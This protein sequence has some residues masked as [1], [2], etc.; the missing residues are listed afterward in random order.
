[1]KEAIQHFACNFKQDT[2]RFVWDL[3]TIGFAS[4]LGSF[5]NWLLL[6]GAAMLI[7]GRL[8]LLFVNGVKRFRDFNKPEWKNI[9][10][11]V[12]KKEAIEDKKKSGWRKLFDF[13]KLG[14]KP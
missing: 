14:A 13:I 11:P 6:H 8:L 10:S 1:M 3:G 2:S 9:V 5:E 7:F 12:L 4:W